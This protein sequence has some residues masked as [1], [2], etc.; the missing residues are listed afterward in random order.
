MGDVYE[1]EHTSLGRTVAIKLVKSEFSDTP[2]FIERFRLELES[3]G[4]LSHPNIISVTDVGK[5][6]DGR[7]FLVMERL[8]GKTLDEEL[9]TYGVIRP[10]EAVD[11]MIQILSALGAAHE[12]G[13][14]HR[15]IKPA[16]VFLANFRGKR[17]VV[18]VLDWGLVKII[19][20]PISK[21]ESSDKNGVKSDDGAESRRRPS[22]SKY[23]TAQGVMLGT[24][25]YAAPEQVMGEKV[26]G[27]TDL[28]ACG[29]VLYRM[30]AGK[31][32][33]EGLKGHELLQAQVSD[34]PPRVTQKAIQFVPED[35]DSVLMK[36]LS[37][38]PDYRYQTAK[39][40][41]DALSVVTRKIV[42]DSVTLQSNDYKI[43]D[44]ETME[45]VEV[46][47]ISKESLDR[48]P[49]TPTG[50][51]PEMENSKGKFGTDLM[52]PH[53]KITPKGRHGTELMLPKISREQ[54]ARTLPHVKA[55]TP[56][57]KK[58]KSKVPLAAM[59]LIMILMFTVGVLLALLVFR[60]G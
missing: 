41:I 17:P 46:P 60:K 32:P 22:P 54:V 21:P 56:V 19:D 50:P 25:T 30:L 11:I 40:F 5:M 57:P 3:L 39:E 53:V 8:E 43:E 10:V 12:L 23:P 1:A 33:F 4:K 37:K 2:S 6:S 36:A 13:I 14:I 49:F 58:S 27:R 29:M 24:P 28:Y 59:G 42:D 31:G 15:D 18:K 48:K 44:L 52:M 51:L 47:H 16:N 38:S 34:K 35:F 45:T 7:S 26:D 55:F 9:K 20:E